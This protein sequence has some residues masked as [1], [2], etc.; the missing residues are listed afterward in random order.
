MEVLC[1]ICAPVVVNDH[2]RTHVREVILSK[3][4]QD[5]VFSEAPFRFSILG[6]FQYFHVL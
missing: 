1:V 3:C 5:K 4:V 6:R 2:R